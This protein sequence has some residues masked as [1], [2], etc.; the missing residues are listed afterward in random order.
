MCG[1]VIIIRAVD[2]FSY[3]L[4]SKLRNILFFDPIFIPVAG[5]RDAVSMRCEV[6]KSKFDDAHAACLS[7][8]SIPIKRVSVIA[9]KISAFMHL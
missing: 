5:A 4:N 3:K 7:L 9:F 6:R 8:F 1:C 2:A